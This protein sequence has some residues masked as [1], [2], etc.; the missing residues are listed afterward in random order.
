MGDTVLDV[1]DADHLATEAPHD[2]D[3]DGTEETLAE[4][5]TGLLG[6]E[7]DLGVTWSGRT[8]VVRTIDDADY[9]R[10]A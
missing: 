10:P 6:T 2:Y 4:E 7:V 9:P 8:A 1:G 5:L 3:G